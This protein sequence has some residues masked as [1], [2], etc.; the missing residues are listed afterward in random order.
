MAYSAHLVLGKRMGSLPVR[1][2]S[3]TASENMGVNV[4]P[5][6]ASKSFSCIW[7]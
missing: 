3:S 6:E 5:D 4:V 2:F 1:N 7:L